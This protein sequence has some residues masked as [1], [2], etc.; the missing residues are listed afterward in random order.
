MTT[1]PFLFL[2]I[3]FRIRFTAETHP[4]TGRL[5]EQKAERHSLQIYFIALYHRV[6]SLAVPLD[7]KRKA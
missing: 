7:G 3:P 2:W 4:P 1:Q 6:F 5:R